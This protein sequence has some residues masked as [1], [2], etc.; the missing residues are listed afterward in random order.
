[1]QSHRRWNAWLERIAEANAG[2]AKEVLA[3]PD[4][5]ALLATGNTA[6]VEAA[7]GPSAEPAVAEAQPL[8]E[9]A[10]VSETSAAVAPQ[11]KPER[12]P[13]PVPQPPNTEKVMHVIE[14]G[15]SL[16]KVAAK[17]GVR[18]EDII[19]WNGMK[20]SNIKYGFKLIIY[21]P[22]PTPE[23]H[24]LSSPDKLLPGQDAETPP[25]TD[26]TPASPVPQTQEA[27]TIHEVAKGENIYRIAAKYHT[28]VQRLTEMNKLDRPDRLVA[29]QKLRVPAQFV[30]PGQTVTADAP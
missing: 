2:P 15:E 12:E 18:P 23:A 22:A 6:T 29:G 10:P 3:A 24:S 21:R 4:E 13:S 14:R 19:A 1:M 9:T 25:A 27:T 8:S 17:Y 5:P 20:D 7:P 28:T 30:K 11:E 26:A 16:G